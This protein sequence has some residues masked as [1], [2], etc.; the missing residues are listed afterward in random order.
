[1]PS[2]SCSDLRHRGETVRRARRVRDDPVCIGVVV[3]V[4]VHP[5]GDSDIRI[6]R[7]RR[8]DHLARPSLQMFRGVDSG[9][10]PTCRL[11]HDV[12]TQLGPEQVRWIGLGRHRDARSVDDECALD[13]LNRACKRPVDGVVPQQLSEH[14]R[15]GEVVDR[16]PFDL[17]FP[18]IGGAESR[19]ACAPET[20]NRNSH[21]HG[22]LPSFRVCLPSKPRGNGRCE[23]RRTH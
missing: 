3:V 17:G 8:D 2:P 4:E 1:M 7:R 6:L 9:A 12:G 18:L 23:H 22:V 20:V 15:F 13:C 19:A 16:Y 10:K 11:D 21:R 5:E 14:R